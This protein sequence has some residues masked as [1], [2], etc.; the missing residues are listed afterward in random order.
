MAEMVLSTDVE[1]AQA[2]AMVSPISRRRRLLALGVVRSVS[3]LH[4]VF[5]SFYYLLGGN[6]PLDAHQ[7][8][9]RLVGAL[10][11]ESTSLRVLWYVL[12]ER[13]SG[14]R[15]IGWTPAGK[16]LPEGFG[17]LIVGYRA[18]IPPV[19]VFLAAYRS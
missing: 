7:H 13:R 2:P 9:F 15:A 4:F 8:G 5:A 14:W 1:V 6:V 10:V 19:L 18:T 16:D 11:A 12:T 17:L 3:L